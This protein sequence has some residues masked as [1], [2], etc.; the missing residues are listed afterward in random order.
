MNKI[1]SAIILA[2]CVG[3]TSTYGSEGVRIS[4]RVDQYFCCFWR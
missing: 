4:S 2:G 3:G 1:V